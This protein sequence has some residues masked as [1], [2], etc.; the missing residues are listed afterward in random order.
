MHISTIHSFCLDI[1]EKTGTV[2]LDVVADDGK[3][4]LFI[5]KHISDLGFDNE[6]YLRGNYWIGNV[7]EKYD[8]FSKFNVDTEGLVEYLEKTF[9]VD[10]EY[11]EFVHKYMEE[12][13]GEFPIDDANDKVFK[14]SYKNA[15]YIQMAK[16]YP[17]Y[18]EL[19]EKENSIDYNQMQIK[20]LEKM[21]EGYMPP[22]YQY[23]N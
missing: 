8:D 10:K 22:I 16:S 21:N 9:P 18:L 20:S 11:V 15:K 17:I 5:K 13:D 1:L 4:G 2:G 19:L 12:N 6:F 23:L 3:L 7:I 14:E